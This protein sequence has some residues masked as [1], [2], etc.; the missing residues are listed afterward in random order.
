[1]L[2][3]VMMLVLL[4]LAAMALDVGLIMW[5]RGTQQNAADAAALAGV[6]LLP[7]D[8][9]AEAT[10]VAVARDYAALNGFDSSDPGVEVTPV[11][12]AVS[13]TS[14]SGSTVQLPALE[15]TISRTLPPGCGQRWAQATS[16]CR[17]GRL[18]S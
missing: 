6:R 11:V 10:A 15:V 14:P 17:R 7:G 4:G 1:M 2:F 18:P 5:S 13:I 12:T 16:S 3:L 8:A 9:S